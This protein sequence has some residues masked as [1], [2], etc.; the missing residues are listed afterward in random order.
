M[1]HLG[2]SRREPSAPQRLHHWK[3]H[4]V[5]HAQFRDAGRCRAREL[6][7]NLGDSKSVTPNGF[8][9]TTVF[10]WFLFPF[11]LFPRFYFPTPMVFLGQIH[12]IHVIVIYR[13]QFRGD[14]TYE[15]HQF[16]RDNLYEIV[17]H[18]SPFHG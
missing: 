3:S 14:V 18:R 11:F 13:H 4:A 5:S 12:G 17:V 7:W 1:V 10:V 15:I 6:R 16:G 2:Y 8:W 9:R